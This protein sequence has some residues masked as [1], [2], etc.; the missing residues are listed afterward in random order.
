MSSRLYLPVSFCPLL[1]Q[2]ESQ[3]LTSTSYEVNI[4][5]TQL[6]GAIVVLP[7]NQAIA[8]EAIASKV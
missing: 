1:F 3:R 8:G 5:M 7:D 4:I 2:E 6:Q